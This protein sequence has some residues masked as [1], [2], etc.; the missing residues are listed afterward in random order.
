MEKEQGGA[1]CKDE[2]DGC[3]CVEGSPARSMGPGVEAARRQMVIRSIRW[4]SQ[5]SVMNVC[6]RWCMALVERRGELGELRF[7]SDPARF[8]AGMGPPWIT[9]T[10]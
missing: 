1:V 7:L 8:G 9:P 5:P 6:R 3:Q 4:G 10:G 2:P